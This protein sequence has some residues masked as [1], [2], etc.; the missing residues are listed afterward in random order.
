M[1]ARLLENLN[2]TS[3]IQKLALVNVHHN[4]ES[5][6][7][8]LLFVQESESLKEIDL[9]WSVVVKGSWPRFFEVL[10]TN[11]TLRD[12]KIGYN[13]LLEAQSFKLT[14]EQIE[15]G[16]TEAPLT[17]KNE[18]SMEGLKNFIKYNPHLIHMDLQMTGLQS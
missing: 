17:P 9:S 4:A 1:I 11:R 12:V 7:Q 3:Q 2:E 6:D 15:A 5:F 14:K 10:N 8:L 13:Q 16:L 18:Q